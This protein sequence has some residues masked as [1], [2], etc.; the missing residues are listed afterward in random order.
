MSAHLSGDFPWVIVRLKDEKFAVSAAN[1]REMVAMPKVVALPQ[2]P[3]YMRGV[4]NLRGKVIPVIDLR[5][6]LGMA[7]SSAEVADL[8]Q[9]MEQREQDHRNWL[10]ELESSVKEKREFKLATDPHKCAF[11]KWYDN[12]KSD[13]RLLLSCLKKFDEPHKRIHAIAIEVQQLADKENH[14]AAF[15]LIEQTRNGDLRKM[16]QL[17]EEARHLL[18][19][20]Q[21]EIALVL[22]CS[23]KLLAA[24]VDSIETVEKLSEDL[25]ENMPEAVSCFDND[26]IIGIGKRNRGQDL[27]QI[28]DVGKLVE[29]EDELISE[30]GSKI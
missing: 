1:V 6:R 4:I 26:C 2:T 11:G 22:E 14:E 24:A 15:A 12:Y 8:I 7:S 3:A 25:I 13:S 28:L 18:K 5:Q 19:E 23:D 9:L 10:A 27:V 30:I 21:R 29:K 20:S 16:I 17:F